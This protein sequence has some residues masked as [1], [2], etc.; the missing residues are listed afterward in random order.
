[1]GSHIV[2]FALV[3]WLTKETGSATILAMATLAA[4]LPQIVLG[5]IAG[6][7][8]DRW[9]R[10]L[11]M[12]VADTGVAL[13]T[14]WLAYMFASGQIQIWHVFLV[15][16]IRS[17][18]GAFHW[19]AAQATTALMVPD[20]HLA[21]VAGLNQTMHG[22]LNIV[23][24]ALG[25][26]LLE[27]LRD[28]QWVVMVDVFTAIPAVLPL[29]LI[30][31][32]QPDRSGAV[33][34]DGKRASVWA[35]FRAGLRYVA[36]WPGLMMVIGIA[37]LIN[38]VLTPAFSLMPILVTQHFQGE[39]PQLAVMESTWGVGVF[40][41][42][43]TLS[44]WGGFKRR[45]LTS[46]AGLTLM[47]GGSIVIGVAPAHLFALGVA[48]VFVV[49]FMNTLTNGPLFAALQSTV[50]ADVQGRVFSLL[51]SGAT[52]MTPLGLLV[53]GPVADAI[54]VQAWFVLGGVVCLATG[55]G[56]C[57][58]PAVMRLE[59]GPPTLPRPAR[60]AVEPTPFTGGAPSLGEAATETDPA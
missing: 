14:L 26:L 37:L 10:R 59:E 55:V 31:I 29:L 15:M 34:A 4:M 19:A 50:A 48:G 33:D 22:A 51:I 36:A 44:V 8:V 27:A 12:I 49:G 7:L 41:G 32:P 25:A 54:G 21:R 5:P 23:G 39:A 57:F 58:M 20:K 53:A 18:G 52:A 11:V 46:L 24:P 9:S 38:F 17:L 43:L 56:A 1:M 13:T 40:L 28:L 6:T 35:E 30:F 60:A 16:F 47:G 42:G 45:L 3:W 2:Q